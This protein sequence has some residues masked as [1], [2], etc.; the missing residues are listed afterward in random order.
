M[1][2]Y[3]T[4]IKRL[5]ITTLVLLLISTLYFSCCNKDKCTQQNII[6]NV[7]NSINTSDQTAF[8]V[9]RNDTIHN[10]MSLSSNFGK[11]DCKESFFTSKVSGMRNFHDITHANSNFSLDTLHV[12][13]F[14]PE[15][16]HSFLSTTATRTNEILKG[17]SIGF[18]IEIDSIIETDL[19]L[20]ETSTNTKIC[21]TIQNLS[22]NKNAINIIFCGSDSYYE[23]CLG[24]NYEYILA[25]TESISPRLLAHEILH[26]YLP[27]VLGSQPDL[28]S[29]IMN[30]STPTCRHISITAQQLYEIAINKINSGLV[31]DHQ[32]FY[33][34]EIA[35]PTCNSTFSEYYFNTI[36]F[37]NA[38]A[39]NET[40]P[41]QSIINHLYNSSNRSTYKIN[42]STKLK[43]KSY[44]EKRLAQLTNLRR[45]N[46]L[47]YVAK[48]AQND[49]DIDKIVSQILKPKV[50][51]EYNI[52]LR[53]DYNYIKEKIRRVGTSRR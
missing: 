34:P 6:V 36:S 46:A 31:V 10:Y 53:K 40:I 28:L 45:R 42:K 15:I 8:L 39:F 5:L 32:S 22:L 9:K 38:L 17:L 41:I 12:I 51:S 2:S 26:R 52:S 18:F 33:F 47:I 11:F 48:N 24:S 25:G 16:D 35:S 44:E 20:C 49:S 13:L 4:N 27:E 30:S 19:N 14:V 23:K 7:N 3:L 21:N 50:E 37:S 1:T 43:V 29:N